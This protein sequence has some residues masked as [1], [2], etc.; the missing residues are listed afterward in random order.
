MALVIPLAIGAVAGVAINNKVTKEYGSWA[1]LAKDVEGK[2]SNSLSQIKAD[3]PSRKEVKEAATA[4]RVSLY[5]G[6][7]AGVRGLNRGLKKAIEAIWNM[8]ASKGGDSPS[9]F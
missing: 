5:K 3:L 6:L 7:E 8:M 2:A 9:F 4:A 1:G